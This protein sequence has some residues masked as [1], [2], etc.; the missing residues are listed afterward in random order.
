MVIKKIIFQNRYVELETPPF[1][2]K[3]IL[4]F[5]F[6][7]LN[8]PLSNSNSLSNSLL[9]YDGSMKDLRVCMVAHVITRLFLRT[10]FNF[11]ISDLGFGS[12]HLIL[13]LVQ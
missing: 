4:N 12:I 3:T 1:M 8:T 9:K 11:I 13:L 2:E 10:L 5:H 7:Y 6:V